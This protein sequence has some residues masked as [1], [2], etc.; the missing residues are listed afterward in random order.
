MQSNLCNAMLLQFET[1]RKMMDMDAGINRFVFHAWM[2][3][4]YL[5]D[6]KH[7]PVVALLWI[8]KNLHKTQIGKILC[9]DYPVF[10]EDV[11]Y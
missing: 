8:K 6:K 10:Y 7:L 4:T 1:W 2:T 11:K 5:F 9:V 3:W